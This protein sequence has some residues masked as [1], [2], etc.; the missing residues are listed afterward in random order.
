MCYESIGTKEESGVI[1]IHDKWFEWTTPL[2]DYY[3]DKERRDILL[4]IDSLIMDSLVV[5]QLTRF[6]FWGTTWRLVFALA[7]FYGLRA[8]I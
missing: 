1:G 2:N 6:V 4:I 7:A 8:F 3:Q 5:I